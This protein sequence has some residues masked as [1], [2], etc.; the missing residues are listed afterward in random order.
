METIEQLVNKK[1]EY[2]FVTEVEEETIPRGLNEDI[3]R[4]ISSIKKEPEWMLEWRLKAYQ[5]WLTMEEPV[6]P[7]VHYPKIDYNNLYYYSAPKI[8]PKLDN[9]SEVDPELLLT[10][11]KLGISLQEQKRL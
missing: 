11:E 7:N 3:V 2:G 10:Y 5:H 4:L 8:K 9:L 6:W 1:Y